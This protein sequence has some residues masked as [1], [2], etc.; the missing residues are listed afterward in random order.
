MQM[1][2]TPRVRIGLPWKL[3]QHRVLPWRIVTLTASDGVGFRRAPWPFP[4]LW[5]SVLHFNDSVPRWK[6]TARP[7]KP[8]AHLPPPTP[9]APLT[10]A[11][12]LPTATQRFISRPPDRRWCNCSLHWSV[13]PERRAR[14]AKVVKDRER[15]RVKVGRC[16]QWERT[17]VRLTFREGRVWGSLWGGQAEVLISI[18]VFFQ[19]SAHTTS[20]M[21]PC[22]STVGQGQLLTSEWKKFKSPTHL[23]HIMKLF[24]TWIL[25]DN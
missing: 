23:Q 25:N 11:R 13:K 6:A 18:C 14:E 3:W 12:C 8:A 16:M 10:V 22:R 21:R 17:C 9:S 15:E 1:D 5:F 20:P 19:M 7:R 2:V 24:Q 4:R